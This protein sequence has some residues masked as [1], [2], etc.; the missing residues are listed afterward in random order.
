M[1]VAKLGSLT[2]KFKFYIIKIHD[3]EYKLY[4]AC[5]DRHGIS[6]A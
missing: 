1:V 3:F 6:N 4:L 2:N 5:K